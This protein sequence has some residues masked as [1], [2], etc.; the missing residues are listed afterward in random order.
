MQHYFASINA[1][2]KSCYD[3][4]SAARKLGLDPETEPPIPLANNMAERVVGLIS[5]VVPQIQQSPVTARI[6][7]LEKE[8][9]QL[10][11]RPGF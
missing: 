11:W 9:G 10:D 7:E 5:V 2:V 3:L 1:E 6:Q 8:F 4:T